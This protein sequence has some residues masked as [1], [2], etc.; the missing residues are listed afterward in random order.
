VRTAIAVVAALSLLMFGLPLA[1]VLSRLIESRA[2]AGLQRDATRAVAMVPDNTVETGVGLHVP[3]STR[4]S[5]IGVYDVKGALVAGRG[6]A[7]SGLARG[8]ADGHEHDGRESSALTVVVP[9]LSDTAVA[10]SVR[11]AVPLARL[12]T[13]VGQAW[14]L[15]ALL[16]SVVVGVAFLLARRGAARISAPFEHITSAARAVGGGNYQIRLPRSGIAEADVAGQALQESALQVDRLIRHEREFMSDA[17]H[18]LRTPL[19]GLILALEEDPPDPAAALDRARHLDTTISDLLRLRAK[20]GPD[21]CDPHDVAAAAARRWSTEAT[22]VTVRADGT[23]DVAIAD[24]ALRQC[25]DVLLDNAIRHGSG[26]VTVTVE[27]LGDAVV[28]EVADH[29]RGFAEAARPGTGLQLATRI[30]ERSG[31]SLVLRRRAPH[32]RVALVLPSAERQSVS[33]R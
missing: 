18:Q 4:D 1:V 29:G 31:G 3:R 6:P 5:Q 15:L 12:Y 26:A 14:A 24:A 17:S 10:G 19:A 13:R 2:V 32:A 23:G 20:S 16:A 22:P 33:Q 27:P 25:L 28:V 7:H 11:A 21:V 9:V 30:V 8:A